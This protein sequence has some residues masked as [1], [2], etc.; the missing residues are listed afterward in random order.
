MATGKKND[1]YE[2]ARN[3]QSAPLTTLKDPDSFGP[4]PKHTAYYGSNPTTPTSAISQQPSGGLGSQARAP[5]RRQ[6]QEDEERQRQEE[7]RAR[8]PSVPYRA[9]TTG[10]RTD[11]LPKPPVRRAD[12]AAPATPPRNSSPASRTIPPRQQPQPPQR[13]GAP[14]T[15]PPRMNENPDEH[16]PPPPPSYNEATRSAQQESATINTG[17][18]NRLGQ[19]GVSVPGFG[20]GNSANETPSQSPSTQGHSSQ[21]SE[22]QQR[23]ARMNSGTESQSSPPPTPTS[24]GA[25][26]AAAVHKKPPPPPKK[27]GLSSASGSRPGTGD[28]ASAPPALP[29]ASKPRP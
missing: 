28:G 18:A 24:A 25:M 10:L 11:N 27:S 12:G 14:P 8:A 26:T 13:Q 17:A 7:E 5:T 21:L 6:Q 29:L 2:S 20:I 22:L 4:P 19:A 15:L 3:H 23:F 9:D 16:T 1:P